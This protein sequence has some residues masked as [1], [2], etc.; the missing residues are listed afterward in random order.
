MEIAVRG[1]WTS[2]VVL[3]GMTTAAAQPALRNVTGLDPTLLAGKTCQGVFNT[4]RGREGSQGALQLRFLVQGDVLTGHFW[5][6][7]SKS[8]YDQAAYAITQPGQRSGRQVT[9]LDYLGE[10]SG[11]TVTGNTIRYVDPIG[12]RVQLTYDQGRLLGQSDPR[13]GAD[14]RMT[15]VAVVRM[16]CR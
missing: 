9:G 5:R 13:G 2:I 16:V 7:V 1:L 6:Q 4:G 3:A 11:L 14:Y 12:G 10:V 15:R 8:A